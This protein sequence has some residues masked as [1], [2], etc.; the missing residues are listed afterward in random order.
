[1]TFQQFWPHYLRAHRRP[2]TRAMHY[3]ATGFAFAGIAMAF[4]YGIPLI[5]IVAILVSYAIALT[6]HRVFEHN[7]SLVFVSAAWGALADLKMCWLALTGGLEAELAR[8]GA[9]GPVAPRG[10]RS[11]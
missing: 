9:T 1:M 4:A 3:L 7:Q 8:H 2:Q 5:G 6:S 10:A 11:L